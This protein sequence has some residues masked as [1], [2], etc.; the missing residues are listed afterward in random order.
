MSKIYVKSF[1]KSKD[2]IHVFEGSGI[3]NNNKIIYNDMG[4]MTKITV[5]SDVYLERKKDYYI[6]LGFNVNKKL[7]GTYYTVD[8]KFEVETVTEYI[9]YEKNGIK[10][11][12][13]LMINNVF[14]GVFEFNLQYTIDRD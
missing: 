9:S 13:K 11:K 14:V 1:L 7:K 10:I 12:Y 8:G 2:E 4:I 3:K 6:K 5:D